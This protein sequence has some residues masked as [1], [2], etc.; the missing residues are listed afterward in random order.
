[1]IA[2]L[3]KR[4]AVVTSPQ[5]EFVIRIFSS[6]AIQDHLISSFSPPKKSQHW[7]ICQKRLLAIFSVFFLRVG[8]PQLSPTPRQCPGTMKAWGA[9]GSGCEMLELPQPQA[10]PG[11]SWLHGSCGADG[12]MALRCLPPITFG[13]PTRNK[14]FNMALLTYLANG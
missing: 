2:I 7:K 6:T 10:K 8:T 4:K 3:Y 1:M 5:P 9:R 12:V 13:P 14:T 11:T